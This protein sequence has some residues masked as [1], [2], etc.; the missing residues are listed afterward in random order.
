[1]KS[2]ILK[3]LKVC[4]NLRRDKCRLVHAEFGVEVARRE[5]EEDD[6]RSEE[7]SGKGR[8]GKSSRGGIIQRMHRLYLLKTKMKAN[9]V[10]E[11]VTQLG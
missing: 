8:K 1:M 4:L 9:E 11:L 3:C 10:E 7:M 5:G 6:I 2:E